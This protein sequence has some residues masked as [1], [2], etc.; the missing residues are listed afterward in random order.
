MDFRLPESSGSTMR[1]ELLSVST[2][3]VFWETN[4]WCLPLFSWW[5]CGG[6]NLYSNDRKEETTYLAE[7]WPKSHR[8]L[9]QFTVLPVILLYSH[10]DT[11]LPNIWRYITLF[12]SSWRTPSRHPRLYEVSPTIILLLFAFVQVCSGYLQPPYSFLSKL[13]QHIN[14]A[15]GMMKA[16]LNLERFPIWLLFSYLIHRWLQTLFYIRTTKLITP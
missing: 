10:F 11:S 2:S 15:R 8:L 16:H 14:L 4:K 6:F 7:I 3:S 1:K 13:V 5:S 12:L 9:C